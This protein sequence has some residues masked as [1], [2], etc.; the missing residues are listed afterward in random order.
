MSRRQKQRQDVFKHRTNENITHSLQRAASKHLLQTGAEPWADSRPGQ[1]W[2]S[3][4]AQASS[5]RFRYSSKRV[6]SALNCWVISP[7][8]TPPSAPIFYTALWR[9]QDRGCGFHFIEEK[10]R[11]QESQVLRQD[12]TARRK[13]CSLRSQRMVHLSMEKRV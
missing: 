10:A 7:D 1:S 8:S 4:E 5:S 2:G 6:A 9:D 12:L 13:I 11:L 3:P